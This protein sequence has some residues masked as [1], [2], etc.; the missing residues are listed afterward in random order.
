MAGSTGPRQPARCPRATG[1]RSRWPGRKAPSPFR[2]RASPSSAGRRYRL[3]GWPLPPFAAW[4]ATLIGVAALAIAWWRVGRDPPGGGVYPRFDP[5]PGLSPAAARF[6]RN[7]GFDDGCLTAAVLS[8]AV[9]GAVRIGEVAGTGLLGGRVY[10]LNPMGMD[11]RHLSPG[12]T[13]AY[14]ALFAESTAPLDLKTD[15]QNGPRVDKARD[16]LKGALRREHLGATFR[17]NR[18][19]TVAA[20]TAGAAIG[21]VLIG[22]AARLS[23]VPVAIWGGGAFAVVML[24]AF[25]SAL[26]APGRSLSDRLGSAAGLGIGLFVAV[27]IA[28][29]SGALDSARD[30]LGTATG[31]VT[32]A[33]GAVYGLAIAL[34][35]RIMSAP[36]VAGRRLM[37]HLDGFALYMKTAEEDRLDR[38]TP[39]ERTP[40]LFERLLPYAVAL[41]LTQQWAAK[42]ADV[43]SAATRPDWYAG[44]GSFDTDRF[45]RDFGGAVA[46]A[47]APAQ[48][49]S[50]GFSGGSGGGSG[51]GGG[52]GGGW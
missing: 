36:T 43:L 46:A 9:K 35:G 33:A 13:A 24:G 41:G 3:G 12:E 14:R 51:G 22:A 29:Q 8:M 39:P 15:K 34:F 20:V 19:H 5:P 30:L 44:T 16:A 32:A 7:R 52:G 6:V 23:P 1:S 49:S 48:R 11:G 28:R 18:G 40:E 4:L 45:G 42:F 47:S 21:A 31:L 17:R 38:L 50:S 10:R 2:R 25:L 26:L 37:D 27:A